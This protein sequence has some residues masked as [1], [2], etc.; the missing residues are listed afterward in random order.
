MIPKLGSGIGQRHSAVGTAPARS[1]L[2]FDISAFRSGGQQ[3]R[4]L[5]LRPPCQNEQAE[6]CSV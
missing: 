5:I 2:R 6:H 4:W 1:K 3:P